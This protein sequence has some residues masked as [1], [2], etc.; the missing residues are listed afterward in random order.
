[1]EKE[2][3]FCLILDRAL[4]EEATEPFDRLGESLGYPYEEVGSL[5]CT[6]SGHPDRPSE[7]HCFTP[8]VSLMDAVTR[9]AHALYTHTGARTVRVEVEASD[10][11][12]AAKAFVPRSSP[13]AA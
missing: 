12:E 2:W 13:G 4:T 1:M 8:G 5:S 7:A 11:P 9:A 6:I 3:E 10:V